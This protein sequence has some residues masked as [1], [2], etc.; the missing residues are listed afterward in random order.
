MPLARLFSLRFWEGL[1]MWRHLV[2]ATMVLLVTTGWTHGDGATK[3]AIQNLRAQVKSLRAL[4]KTE[5][6]D[7]AARY[8]T[9]IAQIKNPEHNLQTIRVQLRAEEKTALENA[10]SADQ[11][12]Q[13]RKEYQDLIK[14]LGSDIKADKDAIKR[15][16]QQKKALEKKVR[17]EFA[18]KIKELEDQ[19]KVLQKQ[20]ARKPKG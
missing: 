5:L 15:I 19:I 1:R 6:K 9:L 16:T 12:K 8:D 17:A 3:Q 14:N 11:K 7:I 18:A 4:E 2:S 13:I 20:G 10:K